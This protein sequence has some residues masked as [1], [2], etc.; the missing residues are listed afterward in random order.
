M[1]ISSQCEQ[2]KMPAGG[3]STKN[4]RSNCTEFSLHKKYKVNNDSRHIVDFSEKKLIIFIDKILD[5]QQKL[6]LVALLKDY[7]DGNVALAWKKGVPL[8]FKV[9][10]DS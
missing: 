6:F 1:I 3:F 2:Q 7:I 8:Y 9:V 5:Q 4:I 10:K